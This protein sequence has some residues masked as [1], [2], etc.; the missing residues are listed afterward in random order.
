MEQFGR[1]EDAVRTLKEAGNNS[2]YASPI[3][4]DV[5]EMVGAIVVTYTSMPSEER[6]RLI[7]E[8]GGGEAD[9]LMIYARRMAAL[10][11]RANNPELV[12]RGLIALVIEDARFD[13]RD[14]LVALTLLHHSARKLKAEPGELFTNA[15]ETASPKTAELILRFARSPSGLWWMGHREV[16]TSSG[17]DYYN[18]LS[19][20]PSVGLRGRISVLLLNSVLDALAW[21]L[22]R[23]RKRT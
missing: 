18:W 11:V 17:F 15:A 7:S 4:N 5:D 13:Y 9:I 1:L 20:Q 2:Y 14:T 8:C 23:I 12:S 21:I 22:S 19:V 16:I 6:A 3:P 10:A